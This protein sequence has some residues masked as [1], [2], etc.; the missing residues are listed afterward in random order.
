MINII[1][2]YLKD[3]ADK[4]DW[5]FDPENSRPHYLGMVFYKKYIVHTERLTFY[6]DGSEINCYY[7]KMNQFN[8]KL[9]KDVRTAVDLTFPDS[10]GTIEDVFCGRF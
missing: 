9:I 10:L 8:W 2:N 3:C 7:G 1:E 4:H 5:K 6:L